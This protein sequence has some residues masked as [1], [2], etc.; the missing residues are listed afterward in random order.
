VQS[1]VNTSSALAASPRA[2]TFPAMRPRL[3][4]IFLS[5]LALPFLPAAESPASKPAPAPVRVA[6]VGDSITFGYGLAHPETDSY[7]AVLA[8]LLGP[9]YAVG[10]FGV[11]GATLLKN[12]HFPYWQQPA[13]RAASEFHAQLVVLKLGTNDNAAKNWS[14][15]GTEFA[16]DAA[17]LIAHFKNLPEKP[18]V[19]VC[20]PAPV[21]TPQHTEFTGNLPEI[22]RLL[23][24]AAKHAGAPVIDTYTP[25]QFHG[26]L[27]PDGLH[28][29]APGYEIIART[30]FAA[31]QNP[32][33][34]AVK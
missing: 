31:V 16:A 30:V 20:L 32:L 5:L 28:P 4:I 1:L 8:R 14:T 7:P 29:T 13:F 21:Y 12:G 18:A 6:C 27:F 25:L 15:H 26:E 11:S 3:L 22:R 17:A 34:A 24:A 33:S 23:A 9:G 2:V 19:W 10:N